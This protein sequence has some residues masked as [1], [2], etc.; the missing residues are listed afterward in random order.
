M[1]NRPF[2]SSRSQRESLSPLDSEHRL[3]NVVTLDTFS[4]LYTP[5]NCKNG[6]QPMVSG[7]PEITTVR[8][9]YDKTKFEAR[10]SI[11][12]TLRV[13]LQ[14]AAAHK[15]T[16]PLI[17][18]V[19]VTWIGKTWLLK[20]IEERY[21]KER[22][23]KVGNRLT[24]ASYFD[25][26]SVEQKAISESDAFGWYTRFLHS[27]VP[28]LEEASGE[29]R[30][31]ALYILQD[32]QSDLPF[33][34]DELQS[35]ATSLKK[36]FT[37]LRE[38]Y[39]PILLLDSTE[40]ID[41]PLLA[42]LE[43][44]ILVPF[45]EGE[46]SLVITAGRQPIKWREPEIR[47]YSDL[48][49]LGPLEEWGKKDI[50]DWVHKEYAFGHAG[51]AAKLYESFQDPRIGLERARNFAREDKE[52]KDKVRTLLREGI[53]KIVLF[54]VPD[55]DIP[56]EQMN[57]QALLW[58]ISILR[59][60]NPEILQAMVDKFGPETY[61]GKSYMFF[62]QAAF[63]LIGSHIA[64]W[65]AGLNDYRVEPLVRRI[66]ANA[67]R[68]VDGQDEYLKRH[69]EAEE[70]YCNSL[71]S[72]ISNKL[73]EFLYHYSVRIKQLQ[74]DTLPKNVVAETRA[75]ISRQRLREMPT[76]VD[77]LIQRL[78]NQ[79]DDDLKELRQDML[80][81]VGKETYQE[82]VEVFKETLPTP[83]LVPAM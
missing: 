45:V 12:D 42:W 38:R 72:T 29:K 57:L 54:E 73:P 30:P 6:K 70:W 32:K 56:R 46:Q 18:I 43:R 53:S 61:Q 2:F 52:F 50:P 21:K 41:A 82:L 65:R 40:K 58:T 48:I 26:E 77:T 3:T 34:P 71:S 33:D 19:G 31:S 14:D 10:K 69:K 66:L 68:I 62:R 81:V 76:E 55:Q 63:N 59:I 25:L 5:K 44:E 16:R 37:D 80:D 23:I 20:E 9:V 27:F 36:W 15:L 74:P 28:V 17:E 7:I 22:T 64:A 39:F 67:V 78:T 8:P 47:F 75:L 79:D 13:C 83:D 1:S 49:R 24:F 4:A 11:L 51:F 60:F 35:V